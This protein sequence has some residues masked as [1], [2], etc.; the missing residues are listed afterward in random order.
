MSAYLEAD[1]TKLIIP[2][3]QSPG[4]THFVMSAYACKSTRIFWDDIILMHPSQRR[5]NNYR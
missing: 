5:S 1:I 2:A 4:K 3:N